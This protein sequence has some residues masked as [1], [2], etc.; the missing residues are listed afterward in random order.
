VKG[1]PAGLVF[2]CKVIELHQ[3]NEYVLLT[4]LNAMRMKNVKPFVLFVLILAATVSCKKEETPDPSGMKKGFLKIEIGLFIHVN[5]ISN[6]LKSTDAVGDFRVEIYRTDGTQVM[7]FEKASDMPDP[8]EMDAGDYY[9][10]AH[11]GNRL[12]AAFDNPWYYGRSD[13]FTLAENS[14]QS[15]VINCE[16]GNSM[17]TVS[18]TDNV[19]NNFTD[20][21]TV[22]KA[23]TDSLVFGKSETR[24]GFFE[25]AVLSVRAVLT[26]DQGG[27]PAVK[28]LT[29]T[30]DKAEACRHYDIR[31]D[32]LPGGG[33]TSIKII[34]DETVD[35]TVIITLQDDDEVPEG[36]IPYGGIIFSEIMANPSALAD[37][38]GEWMEVYNTLSYAVDLQNLVI[39]RDDANSHK[40][41]GSIV[42]EPGG[43]CVLAR[44]AS[45]VSGSPY[46]Y[47]SSI[48]LTNTTT[49]LSI[50]NYGTDGIDGSL[51]FAVTYGGTGFSV[52]AGAS[53]SLSPLHLNASGAQSGSNWCTATSSY[54]TGDLGT[55]ARANDSCD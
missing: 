5:D 16:L 9:V 41:S 11:S 19:K 1:F 49:Q 45:A 35:T 44:M 46:V 2:A 7:V 20:F 6:A 51:I 28:V 42:L 31:V 30:I 32:A 15:V 14:G 40:I 36:T 29:G 53:L 52:P 37:N 23:G 13:D 22:V 21:Y 48:T 24:S 8:V 12:P 10:V 18:Y 34:L 38:E 17:V 26:W 4:Q 3:C 27:A 50:S 39:R 25:P 47:G 43:Y 54:S 55:P 33:G